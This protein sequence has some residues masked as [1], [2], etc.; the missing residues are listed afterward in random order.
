MT[1]ESYV[2]LAKKKELRIYKM[3]KE[4]KKPRLTNVNNYE[5]CV[6]RMSE[7]EKKLVREYLSK[8]YAYLSEASDLY[9]LRVPETRKV[10]IK[11]LENYY[12]KQT[13]K[14]LTTP[15][16]IKNKL[17]QLQKDIFACLAAQEEK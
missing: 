9:M 14:N 2:A 12:F 11:H 8:V 1:T 7:N 16:E 6:Y 10:I 13:F 5:E 4:L 3:A 17:F 15:E